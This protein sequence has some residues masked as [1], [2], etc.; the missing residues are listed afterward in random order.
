MRTA[1]YTR[2][3]ELGERDHNWS[4]ESQER[5]VRDV[6]TREGDTIVAVYYDPGE[7]SWSLNRPDLQ[8]MLAD[9]KAGTF[10]RLAFWPWD[11]LSRNPH[12]QRAICRLVDVYHLQV[13]SSSNPPPPRT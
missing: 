12:H 10:N 4:I 3:S 9:A 11:R 6:C 8:L 5:Q 2:R 1:I 7:D 13:N